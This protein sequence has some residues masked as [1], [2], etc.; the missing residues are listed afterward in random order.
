MAQVRLEEYKRGED[1]EY[2]HPTK[3]V[4][5]S[6][7][8]DYKPYSKNERE[9]SRVNNVKGNTDWRKDPNLPPTYDNYG[10]DIRPMTLVREVSKLGDIVKWPLKTNKPRTNIDSKL[11]CDFH[12]Y[13]GHMALD[14]VALR[15]EIQTLVKKGYLTEFTGQKE[16]RNSTPP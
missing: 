2:Y 15:R 12:G 5:M 14:Y 11:W 13:Y 16:R 1:D 10:F 6:K 7:T 4:S 9:E 8:Q 3:K